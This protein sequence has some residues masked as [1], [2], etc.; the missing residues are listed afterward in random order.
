M[1]HRS[2]PP[3]DPILRSSKVSFF[4]NHFATTKSSLHTFTIKFV[5]YTPSRFTGKNTLFCKRHANF[6]LLDAPNLTIVTNDANL[7]P[8]SFYSHRAY[9]MKLGF[10][11]SQYVRGMFRYLNFHK[12]LSAS[13]R[14]RHFYCVRRHMLLQDDAIE[15]RRSS[16]ADNLNQTRTF[17]RYSV[18]RRVYYF[19]YF[20]KCSRS[21]TSSS[22]ERCAIPC[23][24]V[25]KLYRMCPCHFA[26]RQRRHTPPPPVCSRST[27][28]KL[29]D[30]EKTVTS[31]RL[32]VRYEKSLS[33]S[34][35]QQKFFVVFKNLRYIPAPRRCR[36]RFERL[37]SKPRP[38]NVQ[39]LLLPSDSSK[40]HASSHNSRAINR[41][42]YKF[43]FGASY[44]D[45]HDEDDIMGL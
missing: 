42:F 39:L 16:K 29:L 37:T 31:H 8:F 21:S 5:D 2:H 32:G 33:F 40:A 18:A 34:K 26:K 24:F 17:F 7:R 45:D 28:W 13:T 36:Q 1:S 6:Y 38:N 19:G 30:Q 41:E 10:L 25:T 9:K 15:K 11:V 27:D 20:V 12:N 43:L 4:P 3:S 22:D 14:D 44:D 23:T 35:R